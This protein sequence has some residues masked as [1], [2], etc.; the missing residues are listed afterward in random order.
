M[1]QFGCSAA[2]TEGPTGTDCSLS[3]IGTADAVDVENSTDAA[4]PM[5]CLGSGLPA[6]SK[7]MVAK[8]LANEYI[9]FTKVP[10]AKG[11]GRTMPQ[12]LEGQVIVVQEADLLQMRRIIPDL[13]TWLQCFALY[14]AT[15]TSKY[16]KSFPELMA[17][18]T[19]IAR[20]SQK[21]R[22]PSWVIYKQNF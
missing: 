10:P 3:L 17:Y 20:E 16:P 7:K 5:V 4:Q 2:T 1:Q 8:I 19:L 18:R 6:L 11:K 12:W 14:V 21:Y 22:W 15:L 9:D 13:A